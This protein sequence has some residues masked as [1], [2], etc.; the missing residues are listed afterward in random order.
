MA[1]SK[2]GRCAML[3]NL[4]LSVLRFSWQLPCVG[5]DDAS[6]PLVHGVGDDMVDN[7]QRRSLL[8]RHN[9]RY[10]QV[11]CTA[12]EYQKNKN[13]CPADCQWLQG[14][15]CLPASTSSP[16]TPPSKSPTD[17]PLRAGAGYCSDDANQSC[18]STDEC[19]CAAVFSASAYLDTRYFSNMRYSNE[20]R[21]VCRA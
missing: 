11:D 5:A 18:F 8:R 6:S 1:I 14:T 13:T 9:R 2:A 17:A 15:G 7:G 12:T 3:A 20:S 21:G 4:V 16:S 19:A 10:L